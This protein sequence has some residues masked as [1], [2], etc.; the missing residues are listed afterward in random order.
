MKEFKTDEGYHVNLQTRREIIAI[1]NKKELFLDNYC[2]PYCRDI[3]LEELNN[4]Y[5]CSNP[6]CSNTAAYIIELTEEQKTKMQV[7]LDDTETPAGKI[8]TKR[9][10]KIIKDYIR[11][12]KRRTNPNL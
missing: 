6:T 1:W 2:C 3:L 9:E 4:V 7:D 5:Q 8:H 10:E 11:K 12:L